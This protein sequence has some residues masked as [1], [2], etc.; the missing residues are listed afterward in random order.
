MGSE[1]CDLSFAGSIESGIMR[2]PPLGA[3]NTRSYGTSMVPSPLYCRPAAFGL[4]RA[5]LPSLEETDSLVRATVAVAMHERDDCDPDEVDH[6][7]EQLAAEI[8]RR[9]T[10]GNQNALVA[11][12]HQVLF[13]ECGFSGNVEDYYNP[14]NSYLPCVMR[15]RRGIPATLSLVYKSVAQRLGL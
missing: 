10:S 5:Q 4:F 7:L 8:G 3:S 13:D 15:S 6:T 2:K 9:V 12:L 11:Q 1:R 14:E